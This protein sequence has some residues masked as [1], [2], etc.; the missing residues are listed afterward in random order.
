M[1]FTGNK[2]GFS[3]VRNRIKSPGYTM[4]DKGKMHLCVDSRWVLKL[5]VFTV[6][7]IAIFLLN[8]INDNSLISVLLF[9]LFDCF[10]GIC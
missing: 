7:T 6:T 8:Y 3:F 10:H 2:L 1:Y 5:C 9:L 4:I